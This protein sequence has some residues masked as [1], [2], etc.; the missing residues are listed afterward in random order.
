[1]PRT[2]E[3]EVESL[4]WPGGC[5]SIAVDDDWIYMQAGL[6]V[7]RAPKRAGN[8]P[9]SAAD[10]QDWQEIGRLPTGE[11]AGRVVA[12]GGAQVYWGSSQAL[13]ENARLYAYEKATGAVTEVDLGLIFQVIATHVTDQY[14]VVLGADCL[15]AAMVDR[16]S[17]Q[18]TVAERIGGQ[19]TGGST[20]ASVVHRNQLY[21]D[22]EGIVYQA[23]LPAGQFTELATMTSGLQAL[24]GWGDYLLFAGGGVESAAGL[25]D[26]TT[27]PA[28]ILVAK[29]PF[30]GAAAYGIYAERQR[31][32]YWLTR[33]LGK[34]E[35]IL[36]DVDTWARGHIA[37]P[38]YVGPYNGIAQDDDYLYFGEW[39]DSP[40][41]LRTRKLTIAD[42][43]DRFGEPDSSCAKAPPYRDDSICWEESP[44]PGVTPGFVMP[45]NVA[46]GKPLL[47][48]TTPSSAP[49]STGPDASVGVSDAAVE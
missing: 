22:D 6:G 18:V 20:Y 26:L 28:T 42:L 41:L 12:D 33:E 45:S 47:S 32:V 38:E 31:T 24:V 34:S 39:D 25:I 30:Y 36:L 9:K 2:R 10:L 46:S 3:A 8:G 5:N 1:M 44:V 40:T 48:A 21:C 19:F 15:V 13:Q 16:N 43:K 23:S 35:L 14:V 49:M 27:T 29:A 11:S 7:Y 17:L 37:M 4:Y